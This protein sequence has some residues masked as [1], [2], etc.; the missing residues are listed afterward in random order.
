MVD[1]D[2]KFEDFEE[3]LVWWWI[4]EEW[5]DDADGGGLETR[6]RRCN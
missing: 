5:K 2:S 1:F 6:K 4:I 3:R